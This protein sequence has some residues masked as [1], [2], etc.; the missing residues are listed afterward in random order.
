MFSSE[1]Y[2]HD[3]AM[4]I[5]PCLTEVVAHWFWH[6]CIAHFH[7]VSERAINHLSLLSSMTLGQFI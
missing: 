5:N 2:F 1:L 4:L 7:T 6:T 3:N